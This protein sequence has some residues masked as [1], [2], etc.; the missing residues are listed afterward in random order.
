[1]CGAVWSHGNMGAKNVKFPA[2]QKTDVVAQD[3][4][5]QSAGS[6]PLGTASTNVAL[7]LSLLLLLDFL[8][9]MEVWLRV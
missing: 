8:P 9:Y 5:T 1:M 3:C 2:M 6:G 4:S 7:L